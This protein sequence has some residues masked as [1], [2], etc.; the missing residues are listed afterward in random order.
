MS[1][2]STPRTSLHDIST[3]QLRSAFLGDA[4][5]YAA[6]K[7]LI[8]INQPLNSA[9][10]VSFDRALLNLK[11]HEVGPFWV[12]R[13]IRDQ[14]GPPKTAP[15]ADLALRLVMSLVGAVSYVYADQLND[16]VRALT[17]DGK[18]SAASGYLLAD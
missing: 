15:S 14:S 4:T 9:Q 17:I 10:R 7:R 6:G 12:D 13:R 11:P 3:A 5:E 18:T 1:R 8:P 16:K 2:S